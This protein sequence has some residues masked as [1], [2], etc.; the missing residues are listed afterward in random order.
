M[1]LNKHSYVDIKD[2]P[3]ILFNYDDL[4]LNL[5]ALYAR[6]GWKIKKIWGAHDGDV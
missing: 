5:L 4:H 2:R 3:L 6:D 1:R